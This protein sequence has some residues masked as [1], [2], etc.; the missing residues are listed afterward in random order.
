MPSI[1]CV[2]ILGPTFGGRHKQMI[3]LF[4]LIL[5]IFG[6]RVNLSVAI[7]A[8]TDPTTSSNPNIPV[9]SHLLITSVTLCYKIVHISDLQLDGQ[10]RSFIIFFLGLHY[11]ANRSWMARKHVR[12]QVVSCW[13]N[14]R[15]IWLLCINSMFSKFIWFKGSNG[16]KSIT[17]FFPGL[18]L[19]FD[20]W[21]V[22]KMGTFQRKR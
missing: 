19:S 15:W 10:K 4:L 17:R 13:I 1:D 2:I 21:S 16:S 9:S 14:V 3:L 12:S 11:T 7:V 6:M 8:M 20:A 18:C 22:I 5:I